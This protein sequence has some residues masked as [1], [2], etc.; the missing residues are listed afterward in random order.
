MK[1]GPKAA[2]WLADILSRR[3]MLAREPDVIIGGEE[4]PYL[5]RWFLIPRN[6]RLNGYL[7]EFRRSD[8]DRA[9]HDHPWVNISIVLAGEYTEHSILPGGIH[10]RRIRRAG[11]IVFRWARTAHR[12]EL[13]AGPCISLFLTGPRLREW[14]FHCPNGWVHWKKFTSASGHEVGKGCDL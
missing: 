4:E 9:L 6:H 14:G 10:L 12:I 13:H 2:S 1:I 8:D 5:L 11:D 3:V 7:H